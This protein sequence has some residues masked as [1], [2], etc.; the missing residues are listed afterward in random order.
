MSA[1][2]EEANRVLSL[3]KAGGDE[4]DGIDP[5]LVDWC[6]RTTGDAIDLKEFDE[7]GDQ[8]FYLERFR[9]PA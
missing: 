9:E 5:A 1:F 8:V 4:S 7:N 6:L 2:R 3:W